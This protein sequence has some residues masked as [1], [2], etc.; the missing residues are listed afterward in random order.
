MKKAKKLLVTLLVFAFVLSTFTVG[1]AATS[2][3]SVNDENL[4]KEVV[5][6]MALGYLKGDDQGNLNLDKPITRAEALAIVIRISGLETSADLMKG[7]TKFADVNADPSLQWAT[8]YINLGVGQGIINGY[9][10]GTFR[11]NAN[12]TYAEMAKMIIYAMNYGVTVEGAPW[13]AGVMGKA[14]DLGLFD[15]VN[16]SPDVPAIRG[17]VVMMVDNSLDVA[18]L[19]QTGYGDLKQ[20]EEDPDTTFLSKMKVDELEDARVTAIAR[21]DSALDDDEIELTTYDSK[22][23]VEDSDVYTLLTDETPEALFGLKVDAWINDDD[24]IV[25][26]DVA[27]NAKDILLDTITGTPAKDEIELK[28]ADDT[29]DV[30]TG[31]E[32]YVNFDSVSDFS[33]I[34]VGSYGK[35]VRES[36][37]IAFANLFDFDKKGIVTEV[38]KNVISFVDATNGDDDEIDLSDY[39]DIYVYNPDFSKADVKDIKEYS[40]IFFW[41]DDDEINIVVK[42]DS[43]EGKVD[44][45]KADSIKIDGTWYDKGDDAIVTLDKGD[46]YDVW[47]DKNGLDIVEDFVDED[48]TAVLDLNG[49]VMLVTGAAKATSGDL[50][51]IVTYAKDGR[52][53]TL[54]VF[55]KDGEEVDYTAESSTE[56]RDLV[57]LK[58]Y[59]KVDSTTPL[60]Y[61]ALKYKLTSDSEIAKEKSVVSII[62]GMTPTVDNKETFSGNLTKGSD[63]KNIT[64]GGKTFYIASDTVIMQALNTDGELDPSLITVDKFVSLSIENNNEAVVFGEN[65]KDAKF[66]VMLNKNFEGAEEDLYYGVVT[67]KPYKSGGSYY[68]TINVFGEGEKDYMIDDAADFPKAKVVCFKFNNKGEAT[69]YKDAVTNKEY[70]YDDGYVTIKD[71]GT[72][73]VDSSAILYSLDGSDIDKKISRTALKDYK[74][75]NYVL[76]DS[77]VI[78]AATVSEKKTTGEEETPIAGAITY[79]N[80]DAVAKVTLPAGAEVAEYGVLVTGDK[81]GTAVTDELA[82]IN[83]NNEVVFTFT[84]NSLYTLKLIKLSAPETII[85]KITFITNFPAQNITTIKTVNTNVAIKVDNTTHKIDVEYNTTAA[86]LLAALEP[87]Q[88]GATLKVLS[89]ATGGYEVAGTVKVTNTMVVEVTAK[90]GTTKQNYTLAVKPGNDTG[91]TVIDANVVSLSGTTL[92][93]DEG[94]TVAQLLAAIRL[95]DNKATVKALS[96]ATGGTELAGSAVLTDGTTPAGPDANILRVTAQDGTHLDYTISITPIVKS[97]DTSLKSLDLNKAI[98]NNTAGSEAITIVDTDNIK[99]AADLLT[100]IKAVDAKATVKVLGATGGLEVPGTYTIVP[101]T[102]VVEVTAEDGTVVE[103]SIN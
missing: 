87:T 50:Y 75:I 28:V 21:V 60:S 63:K 26:V 4:P 97:S 37:K 48:V 46:N 92:T 62:T 32:A 86:Q 30:A 90:D 96:K 70:S 71:N 82:L 85:D 51:G 41:E 64:V 81:A 13:P 95:S 34:P 66:I 6:A 36:G 31:A 2:S 12:V 100:V 59:N 99:T 80:E 73:K 69:I 29:F 1:F 83:A 72:Y 15:D 57:D 91:L 45:V 89:A 14:D 9:P 39:D 101:G 79:I 53:V 88:A 47:E 68:A 22:G 55:N 24:E 3:G 27:T 93:V 98:V 56:F 54:T 67:D 18:H 52:Y 49:E 10:D 74:Y 102:T 58:Y 38:D 35:F 61:A 94:T 42:N 43:V 20:Y 23:N 103:Y 40:A 65:G 17:D 7:Q 33:K 11:G 78:V 44:A 76:D 5:R 77:N 8:G 16:A 19:K 25:F 84:N